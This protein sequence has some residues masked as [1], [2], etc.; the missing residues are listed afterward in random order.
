MFLIQNIC[1]SYNY[2]FDCQVE[3]KRGT[4]QT[5]GEIQIKLFYHPSRSTLAITVLKARNIAAVNNTESSSP[6]P[7]VV[8][9][10]V[11]GKR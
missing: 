9:S 3:I 8:I 5:I 6:S 1:C 4:R 10:L 7:F 11:P 2:N